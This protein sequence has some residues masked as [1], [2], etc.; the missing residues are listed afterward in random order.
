MKTLETFFYPVLKCLHFEQLLGYLMVF[1]SVCFRLVA[2]GTQVR[3]PAFEYSQT[4]NLLSLAVVWPYY[5]LT[6]H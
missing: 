2:G 5:A 3:I 4:T 6:G 1:L